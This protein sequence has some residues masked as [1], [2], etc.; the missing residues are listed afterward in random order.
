[1]YV[2]VLTF[3]GTIPFTTVAGLGT[4]QVLMRDFYAGFAPH[5]TAQIDAYSTTTILAFVVCRVAIG[6]VCMGSV[7]R[8]FARRRHEDEGAHSTETSESVR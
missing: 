4:V 1:M 7:A 2:P 6:Y 8:D 5:G 3:V